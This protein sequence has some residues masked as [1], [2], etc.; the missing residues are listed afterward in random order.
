M[1]D[2]AD[3][4]VMVTTPTNTNGVSTKA[5]NLGA[6]SSYKVD[7]LKD[8]NWHAWKIRMQKFLCLNKV[9]KYAEGSCP[10]PEDDP[11]NSA[12]LVVWEEEDLIAQTLIL[13]NI[14]DRQID[15]VVHAE[16]AA[17]MWESLKL[18]HQT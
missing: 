17:Q 6:I 14:D 16:T 15:H 10:K 13:T 1:T 18:A 11:S 8:N 12:K 2:N 3:D 5:R 7:A 4:F 9:F